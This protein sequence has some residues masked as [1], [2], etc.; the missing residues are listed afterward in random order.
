MSDPEIYHQRLSSGEYDRLANNLRGMQNRA[1]VNIEYKRD[2][3]RDARNG[4]KIIT[5]S[6]TVVPFTTWIFGEIAPRAVGTLHQASGNH[7]IGRPPNYI[8]IDDE[9]RVRDAFMLKVPT[10]ATQD[11]AHL[12]DYQLTV[13]NSIRMD[14]EQIEIE[15]NQENVDAVEWLRPSNPDRASDLICVYMGPKYEVPASASTSATSRKRARASKQARII[16]TAPS[17]VLESSSEDVPVS[18]P[19]NIKLGQ[20]YNPKLLADYGGPLFRHNRAMLVQRNIIDTEGKLTAPW[21]EYD[22]LRTA[23]V[24]LMRISLRTYT[25]QVGYRSKKFYQI[26]ADR[27]KI[28]M[29]SFEPIEERSK[30]LNFGDNTSNAANEI[31]DDDDDC[32]KSFGPISHVAAETRSTTA[33]GSSSEASSGSPAKQ[34]ILDDSSASPPSSV[35]QAKKRSTAKRHAD[36]MNLD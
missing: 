16:V 12:F 11:L 1:L 32:L 28:L 3:D 21:Q 23:T 13:L 5:N 26:Y 30:R 24:V 8:M 25:V 15:N 33:S 4:F 34:A 27:I 6:E 19:T 35:K 36:N 18:V 14:D 29:P 22:K 9:T 20:F 31:S 10:L 2:F 7:Y 17:P